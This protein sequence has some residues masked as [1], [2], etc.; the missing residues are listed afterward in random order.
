[1]NS[2]AC[3]GNIKIDNKKDELNYWKFDVL[4]FFATTVPYASFH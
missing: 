1:M 2:V 4:A 3:L